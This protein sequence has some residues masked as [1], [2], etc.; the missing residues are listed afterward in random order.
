MEIEDHFMLNGPEER[1][2]EVNLFD[3]VTPAPGPDLVTDVAQEAVAAFWDACGE[4]CTVQR[5]PIQSD[6][7]RST[8]LVPQPVEVVD[9]AINVVGGEELVALI[10]PAE[11]VQD[12]EYGTLRYGTDPYFEGGDLDA[13]NPAGSLLEVECSDGET[14]SL[15]VSTIESEGLRIRTYKMA[16]IDDSIQ[17]TH[18]YETKD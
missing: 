17:V 15:P 13:E 18:I 3:V 14:C 16:V 7:A 11:P 10:R 12:W 8:P 1:V 4:I 5:H 6:E 2:V 9:G